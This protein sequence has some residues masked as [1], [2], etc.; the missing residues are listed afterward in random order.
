[1]INEK[2]SKDKDQMNPDIPEENPV[3]DKNVQIDTGTEREE[4]NLDPNRETG[5]D[6]DEKE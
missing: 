5:H 4:I 6:N 1:M 2:L 3:P